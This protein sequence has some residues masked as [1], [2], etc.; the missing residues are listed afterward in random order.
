MIKLNKIEIEITKELL[1][2]VKESKTYITYKD[3]C[4]KIYKRTNVQLN[5]HTELP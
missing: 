5:P 1:I 3:L 4:D 2:L